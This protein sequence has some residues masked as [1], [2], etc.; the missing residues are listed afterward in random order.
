MAR[1]EDVPFVRWGFPILAAN[2]G[3]NPRKS[4]ATQGIRVLIT[5]NEIEGTVDVLYGDGKKKKVKK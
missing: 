3:E 2:A 5:E 4:L 1:D